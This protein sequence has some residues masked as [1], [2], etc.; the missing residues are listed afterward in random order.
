MKQKYAI[1]F[2]EIQTAESVAP[3]DL[4][5]KQAIKETGEMLLGTFDLMHSLANYVIQKNQT[6]ELGKQLN[7]QR[8]ALDAQMEQAEEQERIALEEYSKR[9]KIQLETEKSRLKMEL[10]TLTE[11]TNQR[12]NDF[13]F[14]MEEG[15]KARQLLMALIQHEQETLDSFQPYLTMLKTNYAHRKEYSQYC[16]MERRS[17][18]QIRTYLNQMI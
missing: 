1:R 3:A 18:E 2:P 12:V 14:T 7:A 6:K 17:Y 16:E 10:E 15:N 13:A 4:F 11:V 5:S 8:R 9:L